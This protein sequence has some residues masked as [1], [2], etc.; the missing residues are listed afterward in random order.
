MNFTAHQ[1]EDRESLGYFLQTQRERQGFLLSEVARKILV[2][3]DYL[4]YL[5]AGQFKRLPGEVYCKNFIKK[6]VEFLGFE[7]EEVIETFKD[8]LQFDTAWRGTQQTLASPMSKY[9]FIRWPKVFRAFAMVVVAGL[10][11]G[12]LGFMIFQL[13]K[14]PVLLVNS[15][16]QDAVIAEPTVVVE[17]T[18]DEG[19]FV[20]INEVEVIVA[21]GNFSQEFELQKGLNIIEIVSSKKHGRSTS[22]LRRVIVDENNNQISKQ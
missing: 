20:T 2:G 19:A 17:G 8:E 1:I 7:M 5:E 21:Q 18:T 14:P 3:E 13:L 12:Y 6:Y 22:E 11:F 9:N 10:F 4:R 15:P 16:L